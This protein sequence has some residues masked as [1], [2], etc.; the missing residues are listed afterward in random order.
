MVAN[1]VITVILVICFAFIVI[2]CGVGL[3]LAGPDMMEELLDA[4]EEWR[5]VLS[6]LNDG[7]DTE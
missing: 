1:I 7:R 2:A 4:R 3:F 5:R 6:R